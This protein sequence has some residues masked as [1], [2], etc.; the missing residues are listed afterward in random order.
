YVAG[1]RGAGPEESIVDLAEGVEFYGEL[2]V[3]HVEFKR[4]VGLAPSE[5]WACECRDSTEVVEWIVWCVGTFVAVLGGPEV[6]ES[7]SFLVHRSGH[8]GECERSCV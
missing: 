5:G 6:G 2:C 4:G 7:D 3:E 1:F 8:A